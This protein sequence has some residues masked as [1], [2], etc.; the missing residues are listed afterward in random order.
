VDQRG[1]VYAAGP[2][3]IY[4]VSSRGKHLGTITL[5]EHV[6]NFAWGDDDYRALYITASTGLYRVR[7]DVAGTVPFGATE[8][9]AR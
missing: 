5:P 8:A 2:A 9:A 7:L 6:A 3:G 4:V 1:N